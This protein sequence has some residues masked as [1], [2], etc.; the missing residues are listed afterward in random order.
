M[1]IYD[2]KCEKCGK[3]FEKI[4]GI[5]ETVSCCG[6]PSKRVITQSGVFCANEDADWIRRVIPAVNKKSKVPETQEFLKSPT[7]S[8]LKKHLK[9]SGLRWLEPGEPDGPTKKFDVDRHAE[10][11]IQ[12]RHKKDRIELWG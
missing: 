4:A 2:F 1:P 6:V 5:N 3:I 7:R 11:I 10:R 12:H 9:A 8:N